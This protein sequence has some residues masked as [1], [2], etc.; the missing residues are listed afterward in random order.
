MRYHKIVIDSYSQMQERLRYNA[1][2]DGKNFVVH[3]GDIIKLP[4]DN[5]HPVKDCAEDY[6]VQISRE[7]SA[8]DKEKI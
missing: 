2:L 4:R 8:E 3:E 1:A 7:I 5:K 6:R